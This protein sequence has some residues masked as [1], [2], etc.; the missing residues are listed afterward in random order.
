MHV[1]VLL[2]ATNNVLGHCRGLRELTNYYSLLVTQSL[3]CRVVDTSYFV[4]SP[5]SIDVVLLLYQET[6]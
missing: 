4:H 5:E 6:Q 2:D 1:G 3:A